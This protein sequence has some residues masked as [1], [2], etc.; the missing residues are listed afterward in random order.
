MA[1]DN[2]MECPDAYSNPKCPYLTQ[3]NQHTSDVTQIKNALI[4][5]D[6]QGGL[7]SKVQKLEN[8][9]KVTVFISSAA[10][11]AVIGLILKAVFC[12]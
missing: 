12:I 1:A 9:M 2:P 8:F 4:G 6:L 7:V 11:V 3:I 10:V 5:P